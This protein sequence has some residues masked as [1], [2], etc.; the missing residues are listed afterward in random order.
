[1]YYYRITTVSSLLILYSVTVFSAQALLAGMPPDGPA[2]LAPRYL[3]QETRGKRELRACWPSFWAFCSSILGPCLRRFVAGPR[4][5]LG[6]LFLDPHYWVLCLLL[7]GRFVPG[8]LFL[9]SLFL[10][11]LFLTSLFLAFLFLGFLFY[12]LR[13]LEVLGVL[14]TVVVRGRQLFRLSWLVCEL[15]LSVLKGGLRGV[16]WE[17]LCR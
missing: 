10:T 17:G 9:T 4:F 1:M 5:F 13:V 3:G 6:V 7:S 16:L 12:A 8:S 2:F 14:S 11:S 15:W